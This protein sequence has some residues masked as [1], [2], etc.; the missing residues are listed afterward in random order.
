[1]TD[2]QFYW[3]RYLKQHL[4]TMDTPLPKI[5][6]NRSIAM[7]VFGLVQLNEN[8][9]K[10][11]CKN[12]LSMTLQ[13][14]FWDYISSNKQLFLNMRSWLQKHEQQLFQNWY[15]LYST[16]S[17]DGRLDESFRTWKLIKEYSLRMKS[18][19]TLW[20]TVNAGFI[21]VNNLALSVSQHHSNIHGPL[22][23]FLMLIKNMKHLTLSL[24]RDV[25]LP[26]T[27]GL[28]S[29]LEHLSIVSNHIKRF[30]A[31]FKYLTKLKSCHID[32]NSIACGAFNEIEFP[33]SIVELSLQGNFLD[34][35]PNG[36]YKL[37]NLES[38]DVSTNSV[39]NIS[40]Q[41]G[42]LIKLQFLNLSKN[43]L[44]ELPNEICLLNR[45]ELFE[46]ELNK[47]ESLPIDF[48]KLTSLK[49]VNM[50]N[51]NLR[52]AGNNFAFQFESFGM[53]K[54]MKMD[55]CDLRQFPHL[56]SENLEVLSIQVSSIRQLP[57]TIIHLNQLTILDLSYGRL[58]KLPEAIGEL[59]N[60]TNL[61]LT[62]NLLWGLPIQFGNLVKLRDLKLENNR[63]LSLPVS[64]GNLKQLQYL[65]LNRNSIRIMP[66]VLFDLVDLHTLEY[67]RNCC[68]I[69]PE[70][71]GKLNKL[72][73]LNVGRNLFKRIPTEIGELTQLTDLN[74]CKN[75]IYEVPN[76]IGNLSSL[77]SL[78]LRKNSIKCI[79]TTLSNLKALRVLNLS[80]NE[81]ETLDF[82]GEDMIIKDIDLGHNRF[83]AVPECLYQLTEL[84]SLDISHNK[85]TTLPQ[86]MGC[87][88]QLD[89]LRA[90]HNKIH[91]IE[92]EINKLPQLTYI[93]LN[94][95]FLKE[96][97]VCFFTPKLS[98]IEL[99][100]N[101]F[102]KSVPK[103]FEEYELDVSMEKN[104]FWKHMGFYALKSVRG[105]LGL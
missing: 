14:H 70:K 46:V 53:L 51:N 94:D 103:E 52:N 7:V 98:L 58:G 41:I 93:L 68:D 61:N 20:V 5:I 30:P 63:L 36:V 48:Q 2:N 59:T 42:N 104:Q 97:P 11:N 25:Y 18:Q 75:L 69:L 17:E 84:T 4:P 40:P 57:D 55:R 45:L 88:D 78:N 9:M 23:E 24:N 81:F 50:Q 73:I 31:S 65:N 19:D 28:L 22:P 77:N 43:C 101:L 6:G 35:I 67:Y 95:N 86:S 71:I 99:S 90:Q 87:F 32:N 92:I 34:D 105:I 39:K 16:P 91:S 66:D 8:R 54:K 100:N 12:E 62:C 49:G 13:K 60:L 27:L 89:V 44:T 64:F 3:Y 72:V 85:I 56:K 102:G 33:V 38:L 76:S 82:N 15:F 10:L 29:Q 80:R 74:L 37:V 79:P 1:M 21:R 47:I 26:D 96:F 83:K